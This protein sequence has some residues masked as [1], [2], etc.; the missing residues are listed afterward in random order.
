M[1]FLKQ[2]SA[3]KDYLAILLGTALMA[4]AIKSIY[5]AAGLV[6]GG[7]TG[8]SIMIKGMSET[9]SGKGVPL[10]FTN[11]LLNIPLFTVAILLKGSRFL[12][13]SLF[14][15]FFLSVWLYVLPLFVLIQEDIFLT[16]LFGGLLG[17]AGIGIVLRA[18]A[19]TGG[20]DLLATLIHDY[21]R[22]YAVV[23]IMMV[24]DAMIIISGAYIFGF[25]RALYAVLAVY[26]T[27]R[28]SDFMIEGSK[29]AKVVYIIT[30]K[31]EETAL[32]IMEELKRG[33]TALDARG[34]YTGEEKDVLF[35]VVSKKETV[36]LKEMVYRLDHNAFVIVTDAREVL[37]EG[38]VMESA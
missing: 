4:V 14:G 28:V 2:G 35:C 15:T 30:E 32:M 7:F 33:A 38:F 13:K 37:G 20:V 3:V 8:I 21:F 29:F 26:I 12:W 17:G 24:I 16:A 1:F 31:Y 34:M 25:N 36:R 23:Q 9:Y 11:L 27:T 6:T 22:H 10:W 5:D 18:G 19:T